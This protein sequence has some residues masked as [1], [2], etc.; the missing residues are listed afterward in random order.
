VVQSSGVQPVYGVS[1]SPLQAG[2]M[3]PAYGV[4]TAVQVGTVQ[5]AYGVSTSVQT[6]VGYLS[7]DTRA[8]RR[9]DS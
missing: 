8:D 5:P 7:V 4:S 1:A 3:Q 2:T 6:A 9:T